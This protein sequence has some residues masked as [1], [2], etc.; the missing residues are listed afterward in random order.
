MATYLF[1]NPPQFYMH[2]AISVVYDGRLL[3]RCLFP[4]LISPCLPIFLFMSV[5]LLV[6]FSAYSCFYHVFMF[7]MKVKGTKRPQKI[8]LTFQKKTELL[9]T[10]LVGGTNL[11]SWDPSGSEG[12]V[13]GGGIYGLPLRGL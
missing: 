7:R 8:S 4:H 12:R 2:R 11:T 13:S 10:K 1:L 3:R 6:L 9:F 5:L